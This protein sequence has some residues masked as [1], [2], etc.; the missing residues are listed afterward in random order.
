LFGITLLLALFFEQRHVI[1]A[2]IGLA[3]FEGISNQRIPSLIAGRRALP[4]C[5]PDEGTLGIRFTNR[6]RFEAERAWR[7]LVAVMLGISI[8]VFPD[9]L[10]FFPWFMGYA[11]MGAGASGVC[12][13][14]LGLKWAG[15][16]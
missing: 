11:M 9:A 7:M 10:W 15:L 5:N 14:Y 3:F 4:A 13:M 12:P 2:L 1:Y 16:K 6:Y 8:F